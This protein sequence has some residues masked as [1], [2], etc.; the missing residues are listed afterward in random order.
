MGSVAE[1]VFRATSRTVMLVKPER[2]AVA[3][4]PDEE[5]YLHIP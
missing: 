5:R 4:E 2:P 3:M 1:S